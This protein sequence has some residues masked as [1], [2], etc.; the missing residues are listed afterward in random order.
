M[1]LT[2]TFLMILVVGDTTVLDKALQILNRERQ[3]FLAED[4]ARALELAGNLGFS[5]ALVDLDLPGGAGF[6]LIRT[7]RRSVPDLQIIAVTNAL[8]NLSPEDAEK[9]GV[10][11]VLKK[12]ITSDWK[13]VVERIRARRWFLDY[14]DCRSHFQPYIGTRTPGGSSS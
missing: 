1:L 12:P 13:P 11:A 8:Y 14:F 6:D 2:L 9:L 10:V 3:V 5:V 4:S 7:L